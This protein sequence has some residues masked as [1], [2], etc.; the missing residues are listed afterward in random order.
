MT[1]PVRMD[2]QNLVLKTIKEKLF[3]DPPLL[4]SL[5]RYILIATEQADLVSSEEHDINKVSYLAQQG[6]MITF[7][8]EDKQEY[9]YNIK[10][11]GKKWALV[12]QTTILGGTLVQAY[13]E[14]IQAI[15][16]NVP[17]HLKDK[18]K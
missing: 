16:N 13:D 12:D 18:V 17:H 2:L 7:V 1:T 3:M 15:R 9:Y 10:D 8:E 5:L 4:S 11:Y 6:D 14:L